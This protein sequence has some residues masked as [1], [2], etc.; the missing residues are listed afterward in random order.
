MIVVSAIIVEDESL[1]LQDIKTMVEGTGFIDV[2]NTYNNARDALEGAIV[3]R[4]QL[5]FVDIVLPGMDGIT[6]AENLLELIPTLR[7][8]FITAYHEYAVKAFELNALDYL[9]KPISSRRFQLLVERIIDAANVPRV[10]GK[11][12]LEI[13]CFG[14]LE[15]K[16]SGRPVRWGRSTAEE[17][18]CYLLV[19]HQ[20]G[21]HKEV[22][23]EELWPDYEPERGLPILQTAVCKLRNIFS[24]LE[25][26]VQLE[27]AASKYCLTISDCACDY[28][29]VQDILSRCNEADM[30]YSQVEKAGQLISKGF[31]KGQGYLWAME[32]EADLRSRL[33]T[34]LRTYV[35]RYLAVQDCQNAVRPL[36]MLLDFVP[37]DEEG[38]NQLLRCYA[39]LDDS[40][41]IVEHYRWLVRILR[42]EYDMEPAVSTRGLY[43]KLYGERFS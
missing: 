6:L 41:G 13:H 3:L 42:E 18:F 36:R 32:Q 34:V 23:L 22:I 8:V 25:G 14:G 11:G 28:F 10:S 9:L 2:V 33:S 37:Y 39:K 16:I 31:L 7:V 4:P 20:V 24:S 40:V 5:A 15:V 29:L 35:A 26:T 17:L 27:Y 19:N 12:S 1:V 21:I 30:D 43:K 38:N